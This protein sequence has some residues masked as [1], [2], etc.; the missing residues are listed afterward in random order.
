MIKHNNIPNRLQGEEVIMHINRHW[1]I[2]FKYFAM[3]ALMTIIP[4]A[5]HIALEL[6]SPESLANPIF[7]GIY[8]SIGSVYYMIVLVF[9]LTTWM[10]N[11]LD[12]WTVTNM[13]I[14]NREQK[15]LFNRVVSQVDLAKI[16]DVTVEQKGF[17]VTILNYGNVYIQS[18]GEEERFSFEQ[19]PNP[20]YI[21]KIIQKLVE[22][23][24]HHEQ[25]TNL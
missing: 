19:V 18:A 24:H 2:F 4:I 8:A 9:A 15:G 7:F 10:D 20:A 1:F 14:I 12:V 13:K 11:Y 6:V 21:A 17:F 3:V 25:S 16:Q 22:Q 5:I 23:Q